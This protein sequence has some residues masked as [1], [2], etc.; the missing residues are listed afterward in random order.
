MEKISEELQILAVE[1][2][3]EEMKKAEEFVSTWNASC[4]EQLLNAHC[5]PLH[6]EIGEADV[7]DMEQRYGSRYKLANAFYSAESIGVPL[8]KE[9][10]IGNNSLTGKRNIPFECEFGRV[11]WHS[12]Y[13]N[14][15]SRY[16]SFTNDGEICFSKDVKKRQTIQHSKQISYETSY[17]VLSN[18]FTIDIRVDELTKDWM[19]EYKY[20]YLTLSLQGNILTKKFNDIEIIQD[21]NTGVKI[22]RIEKK[23]NKMSKENNASVLF[24]AVLNPDDNLE[25]GA[26]VINT[27]K[28]NGKVNGTFRFDVSRTKG[29]RANFYSRKGVK[30]DLTTNPMLLG[31]VNTLLLPSSN[32]NTG[33]LIVS[34]FANSTQKTIA[35]NLSER[36]ISFDSSDFNMEA[37]KQADNRIMEMVKSIRGELP[38][39]GL[40]ERVDN[41]LSLLENMNQKKLE[42]KTKI[43]KLN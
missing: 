35:K 17:N 42:E 6:Y 34:D 20:E 21:L 43:L 23:Y 41:C 1:K 31:T 25:M 16:F 39:S 10:L 38:L 28:G 8:V 26:V 4:Y 36:V 22:V 11:E 13:S 15:S 27:H 33:D 12:M 37:V 2:V 3:L 30:V 9:T 32:N 29:V 24:E 14:K 19:N 7:R 5:L 18:D 40:V